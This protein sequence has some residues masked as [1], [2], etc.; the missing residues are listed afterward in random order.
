MPTFWQWFFAIIGLVA[1]LMAMP[2]ILQL[3]FGQPRIAVAFTH[4]DNGSEGRL[5]RMHLMNPPINNRLLKA[6]RVSRLPVQSV[7]LS[8]TVLNAL[9]KQVVT[10]SFVPEIET[11]LSPKAIRANLPPSIFFANIT[12]AQWQRSTNSAV[13]FV[14]PRLI[15]LVE[16]AYI[17]LIRFDLDGETKR[18]KPVELHI[19]KTE[20]EMVW[21]KKITGKIFM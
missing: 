6:L 17:F 8:V 3:L 11:Y 9:T 4:V 19:G 16:G 13:L 15:P 7:C 5:I 12:L 2:Y 10:D 14:G 18:G 20:N 1:F 21:D